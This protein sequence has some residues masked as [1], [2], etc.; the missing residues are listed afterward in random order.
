M[1]HFLAM[2][3]FV[4]DVRTFLRRDDDE[5]KLT[6]ENIRTLKKRFENGDLKRAA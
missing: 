2:L 4:N 5:V 6:I 1:A 3:A